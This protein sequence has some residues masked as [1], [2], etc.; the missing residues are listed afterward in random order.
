[1]KYQPLYLLILALAASCVDE[2][3]PPGHEK[4]FLAYGTVESAPGHDLFIVLDDKDTTLLVAESTVPLEFFK[5][6]MRLIV[7]Y[8]IME[9]TAPGQSYHYRARVNQA[10][11]INTVDVNVSGNN[12]GNDP[13]TVEDYWL[14]HGFLT[15]KYRVRG[16]TFKHAVNLTL[17]P[18]PREG[19]DETGEQFIPLELQH[20]DAGDPDNET[21]TDLVSF[22]LYKAF[23]G[24][25][26]PTRLRIS[27]NDPEKKEGETTIEIT[28]YPREPS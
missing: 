10:V 2:H 8:S 7:D 23:P 26:E 5:N 21:L 25:T 13:I 16:T 4:F 9:K 14:A 17:L 3:R 22:P 1:M 28:Y 24:A 12:T 6:E 19:N 18:Y 20:D 15:F 11:E 27:Y